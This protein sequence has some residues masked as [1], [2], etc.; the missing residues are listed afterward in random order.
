MKDEQSIRLSVV[1]PAHNEEL[2]VGATIKAIQTS[3]QEAGLEPI[4]IIVVDDTSTDRTSDISKESGA[5][6]FESD[7]RNIGATRNIGGQ[8]AKG[9]YLLFVDADTLVSA[10][11]FSELKVVLDDMSRGSRLVGGGTMIAWNGEVKKSGQFAL[12]I[13]NTISRVM[14]WPAG[15]FFY[16]KRSAFQTVGGFDEEYFASEEIHLGWKLRKLGSLKILKT[17]VATSPR[18]VQNYSAFEIAGVI[19]QFVLAPFS[20]AKDREKLDF[21]YNRRD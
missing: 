21:W 5:K 19:L 13:W 2:C 16:M 10:P 3:S 18:K 8:E 20:A 4:E 15:S 1:I 6:V 14:S 12:G 7:K 9:E 11:L 17:P